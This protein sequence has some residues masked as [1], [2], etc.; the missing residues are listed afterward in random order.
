MTRTLYD[1][2]FD[3]KLGRIRDEIINENNSIPLK[4]IQK[5]N[6]NYDLHVAL[7]REV[8]QN[9]LDI[10]QRKLNDILKAEYKCDNSR[11]YIYD[12]PGKYLEF[13]SY[14]YLKEK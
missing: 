5:L 9:I 1:H 14:Y 10:I 11:G 8:D 3:L 13:C 4:V 7:E 6:D 12:Y 2:E